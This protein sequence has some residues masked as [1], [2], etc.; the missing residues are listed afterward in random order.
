[1]HRGYAMPV[2]VDLPT[3][4]G[5]CPGF[6]RLHIQ[7]SYGRRVT[8]HR[9][10]NPLRLIHSLRPHHAPCADTPCIRSAQSGPR[11]TVQ[12]AYRGQFTPIAVR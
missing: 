10:A 2:N 7:A 8:P 6:R 5:Q 4:R 3:R 12:P 1:M 11:P 9:H